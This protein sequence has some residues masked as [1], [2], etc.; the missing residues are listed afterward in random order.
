MAEKVIFEFRADHKDGSCESG[1]EDATDGLF[2]SF[3]SACCRVTD[4]DRM[5]RGARPQ[6]SYYRDKTRHQMRETLD[7]FEQMYEDLFGVEADREREQE[8]D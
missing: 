6:R 4:T 1:F 8:S 2:D 3:V 5:S 7:L